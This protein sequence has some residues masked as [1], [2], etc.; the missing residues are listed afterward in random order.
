MGSRTCPCA[1]FAEFQTLS[2]I[3]LLKLPGLEYVEALELVPTRAEEEA[4]LDRI[5]AGGG[6]TTYERPPTAAP[7]TPPTMAPL[8][9]ESN[10]SDK[11][12]P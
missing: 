6:A 3:P 12:P 4:A 9:P 8:A 2:R 10:D 1:S 11:L 7:M 5:T